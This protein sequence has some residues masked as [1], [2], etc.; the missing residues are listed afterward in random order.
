MRSAPRIA[1]G[2]PRSTWDDDTP[3]A[4]GIILLPVGQGAVA[5]Y[6]KKCRFRTPT[7]QEKPIEIPHPLKK[8]GFPGATTGL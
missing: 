6:R 2:Q 3:V 8:R 4:A 5:P 7:G 1:R